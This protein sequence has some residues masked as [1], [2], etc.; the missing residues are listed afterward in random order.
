MLGLAV[1]ID[2]SLFIVSRY[3]HE[4]A[5]GRD[6]R[7]GGRPRGRHR[8]LGGGLR[9]H[10]RHHRPGRPLRGAHP[11]PDPDGPGRRGHRGDRR[12]SIALTLLPALLGFAGRRV[13]GARI[14]RAARPRP[15]GRRRP[16]RAGRALGAGS[17]PAGRWRCCS[18]AV[19][20]LLGVVAIPAADLRLGCP[21][22]A[23][24]RRTPPSARRTTCSP[25]AS[26][27]GFNG[28]LMVVVDTGGRRDPQGRG[29]PVA[30][31]VAGSTTSPRSTPAEFNQAGD[32]AL[33]TVIPTSGP[34][35]QQTKDLV[36]RSA[37]RPRR[38]PTTGATS[39][40]P[41]RPPS[42]STCPTSSATRCC[43]TCGLVVGL[44][45]PAADAGVPVGPG[46]AQ[47]HARLPAHHRAPRSARW[48]RSSSGAGWPTCSASSQTGPIISFLP[49]FL[50]GIVFG[51]A[52]D[53]QVFLV[54]RMRE[55]YVHGARRRSGRRHRLPP[56]RPGGHRR[57]D[58][59]DQRLR[60][61][62]P[63]RRATSSSRSASRWPSRRS[64]TPSWSG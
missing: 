4:L 42:T 54:T 8:R 51:L 39:P 49:I 17:S 46:A 61:V 34:S 20:R 13:L 64:S 14:R 10:D 62:H 38:S 57:R 16:A 60:R 52:M 24:P 41:A 25:T 2:Y 35:S 9:R 19:A 55:E 11:V 3:R 40:S 12:C 48:W 30:D 37:R 28:P 18:L 32:T 26:V 63:L 23:P 7:G 29:R 50:I 1:A 22:T 5:D 56:R 6:P 53:Y 27:P 47:G 33:L 44:A 21:T 58:H 15:G 59:H 31:T 43:R 36:T 45:V